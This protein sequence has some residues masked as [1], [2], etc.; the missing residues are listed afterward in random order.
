MINFAGP[1]NHLGRLG[2]EFLVFYVISPIIIK[3][4]VEENFVDVDR[5]DGTFLIDNELE[6]FL[7]EGVLSFTIRPV[8]P[9][10]KRYVPE[11]G[12]NLSAYVSGQKG[13]IYLAYIDEKVCGQMIV[14]RNW[15]NLA[16]IEELEVDKDFRRQGVGAGLVAQAI[17]WAKEHNLPGIMLETQSNNV[18]ACLFYQRCGFQLRG[19]DDSLYKSILMSKESKESSSLKA[20]IALYWY[21]F[22]DD[23]GVAVKIAE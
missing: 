17:L 15:N 21:Y 11:P 22:F 20:E 5:C 4:I 1:V 3:R 2:L 6:L 9:Y 18:S 13:A 10:T 16:I 23:E 8:N 14:S 19:F 7:Q 12:R